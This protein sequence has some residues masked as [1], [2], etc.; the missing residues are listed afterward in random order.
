MRTEVF[1]VTCGE[2]GTETTVAETYWPATR[3][4]PADGETSPEECPKCGKPWDET[5]ERV[6]SD[7]PEPDYPPEP[8][9]FD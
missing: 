7:P 2:C 9:D 5:D 6:E 4:D 1:E 3:W 8:Y